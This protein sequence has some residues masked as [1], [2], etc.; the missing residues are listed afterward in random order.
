M[1]TMLPTEVRNRWKKIL[2]DVNEGSEEIHIH[3]KR[4]PGAVLLSKEHYE[5][6][7][8]TLEVMSDPKAVRAIQRHKAGLGKK[9]SRAEIERLIR[10]TA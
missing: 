10:E 7:L 3:M 8:A 9:H 2:R 5:S 1:K 4:G 6:L